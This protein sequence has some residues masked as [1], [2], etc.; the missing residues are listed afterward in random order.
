[1]IVVDAS[2]A[3]SALLNADAARQ[4]LAEEDVHVPHLADV[5]VL[6][7]LRRS[8]TGGRVTVEAADAALR[9]WRRLGITRHPLTGLLDRM[10]A[11]RENVS[12]YDAAYVALA[13]ALGCAVLTAD[14]R[15][16][17]A[18]GLRCPVTVVPR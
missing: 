3:V 9:T 17:R 8:V 11:L 7:A 1:M 6:S 18:P 5:E 12:A 14:A 13:E 2:A 10:W 4:A 15:L 16:S